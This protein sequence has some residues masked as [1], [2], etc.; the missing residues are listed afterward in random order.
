MFA[1]TDVTGSNK[2]QEIIFNMKSEQLKSLVH[3]PWCPYQGFYQR[4]TVTPK[5]LIL[6]HKE[7]NILNVNYKQKL[8]IDTPAEAKSLGGTL[9]FLCHKT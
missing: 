3:I 2:L 5:S 6:G 8:G 1:N 4:K 7:Q 9:L